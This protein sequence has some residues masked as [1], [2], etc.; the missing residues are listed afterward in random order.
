MKN[1]E[2]QNRCQFSKYAGR[3]FNWVSM[4]RLLW[5]AKGLARIIW[6]SHRYARLKT[7]KYTQKLNII[8]NTAPSTIVVQQ[9]WS[10]ITRMNT[11]QIW[12][13]SNMWTSKPKI[14]NIVNSLEKKIIKVIVLN[15]KSRKR[16]HKLWNWILNWIIKPKL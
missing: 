10:N 6:S 14:S 3:I 16:I 7:W 4:T 2:S 8:K 5:L 13:Q 9:N 1:I 15:W 11:Q 12:N